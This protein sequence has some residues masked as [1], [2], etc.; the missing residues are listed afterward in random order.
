MLHKKFETNS[1]FQMIKLGRV[2]LSVFVLAGFLSFGSTRVEAGCRSACGHTECSESVQQLFNATHGDGRSAWENEA[3]AAAARGDTQEAREQAAQNNNPPQSSSSNNNSSDCSSDCRAGNGYCGR[4]CFGNAYSSRAY[5]CTQSGAWTNFDIRAN[6]PACG[7]QAPQPQSQPQQQEQPQQQSSSSGGEATWTVVCANGVTHTEGRAEVQALFATSHGNNA[8]SVWQTEAC[9]VDSSTNNGVDTTTGERIDTP[10]EEAGFGGSGGSQ[11]AQGAQAPS[12]TGGQNDGGAS[13]QSLSV[14]D[15]EVV[16]PWGQTCFCKDPATG[17]NTACDVLGGGNE[18][19][20]DAARWQTWATNSTVCGGNTDFGQAGDL[21]CRSYEGGAAVESGAC[22]QRPPRSGDWHRC[23][24]GVWRRVP[25]ATDAQSCQSGQDLLEIV[26][27]QGSADNGE[28]PSGGAG[29]SNVSEEQGSIE[30][31]VRQFCYV[32]SDLCELNEVDVYGCDGQNNFD[33]RLA[34]L[35]EQSRRR[36]QAIA[37]ERNARKCED[38]TFVGSCSS[39]AVGKKCV[40]REQDREISYQLLT[41]SSC[42]GSLGYRFANGICQACSPSLAEGLLQDCVYSSME[43]CTN[44]HPSVDAQSGQGADEGEEAANNNSHDSYFTGKWRRTNPGGYCSRCTNHTDESLCIYDDREAC[45][46]AILGGELFCWV[47]DGR[48]CNN[49]GIIGDESE[50]EFITR[51]DCS[52]NGGVAAMEAPDSCGGSSENTEQEDNA[53]PPVTTCYTRRN[54]CNLTTQCAAAYNPYQTEEGCRGFG[55]T[56]GQ[57][58][59]RTSNCQF[60]LRCHEVGGRQ[61]CVDVDDIPAIEEANTRDEAIRNAQYCWRVD[62][63]GNC[64]KQGQI[65][66]DVQGQGYTLTEEVCTSN[67]NRIVARDEIE[68]VNSSLARSRQQTADLRD[69]VEESRNNQD[70][71]I[72]IDNQNSEVEAVQRFLGGIRTVVDRLRDFPIIGGLFGGGR[73]Q[74]SCYGFPDDDSN[75]C[76]HLSE[77]TTEQSCNLVG[78]MWLSNISECDRVLT[79]ERGDDQG[80]GL[81][82]ESGQGSNDGGATG[83]SQ[84]A[85]APNSS[86]SLQEGDSRDDV[87]VT[88][89]TRDSELGS[90]AV[91][92]QVDNDNGISFQCSCVDGEYKFGCRD[93]A[94]YVMNDN[95]YMSLI[96]VIERDYG[97]RS[98]ALECSDQM[99]SLNNSYASGSATTDFGTDSG[100]GGC[101]ALILTEDLGFDFYTCWQHDGRDT[102]GDLYPNPVQIF[103]AA[104]AYQAFDECQF[105]ENGA[106][107]RNNELARERSI[108]KIERRDERREKTV[109]VEVTE[110]TNGFLDEVTNF[111]DNPIKAVRSWL[112]IGQSEVESLTTAVEENARGECWVGDNETGE[113]VKMSDDASINNC[114]IIFGGYTSDSSCQA[115][116]E[117]LNETI[118]C[119]GH[120]GNPCN[121]SNRLSR[122]ECQRVGGYEGKQA[123]EEARSPEVGVVEEEGGNPISTVI[124]RL[125]DGVKNMIASIAN[126]TNRISLDQARRDNEGIVIDPDI[127]NNKAPCSLYNGYNIINYVDSGSCDYRSTSWYRCDDGEWIMVPDASSV[128]DC[129]NGMDTKEISEHPGKIKCYTIGNRLINGSPVGEEFCGYNYYSESNCSDVRYPIE[130]GGFENRS[131]DTMDECEA[132]LRGFDTTT[133][134]EE[135]FALSEGGCPDGAQTAGFIENAAGRCVCNK[136]EGCQVWVEER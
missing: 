86:G 18:L 4:E 12:G 34:C 5:G 102:C 104:S 88:D 77:A 20:C 98:A 33:G 127:N 74:M 105:G 123:C 67:E 31:P 11:P 50:G 108:E 6:D 109:E 120:N 28:I 80:A 128:E 115:A 32:I 14:S 103:T 29:A 43:N 23:D 118:N 73:A 38:G 136:R 17:L 114:Q 57:S 129:E 54:D 125:V 83:Q 40:Q 121:F 131:F 9:G 64:I 76:D 37:D 97:E 91:L 130:S 58:C 53:Y 62:E 90:S 48:D 8:Q 68:C 81:G 133:S 49:I 119:N 15:L 84:Q 94:D 47:N 92:V 85:P 107:E 55:V 26:Q 44:S 72:S 59:E 19:C 61:L 101:A 96:R 30:I 27:S 106:N 56:E 122:R 2:L 69:K 1:K 22:E 95:P 112:G 89:N 3:C 116:Q 99:K 100:D 82:Q 60:G 111:F 10:I 93:H 24:G 87:D 70:G 16:G 13:S 42:S 135:G 63:S 110:T 36:T 134:F 117:S 66:Q 113:C 52:D 79:E 51:S 7:Y 46:G 41:D 78:G 21:S 35:R 75:K 132:N 126:I 45:D 25:S 65:G 39:L 124:T 71:E